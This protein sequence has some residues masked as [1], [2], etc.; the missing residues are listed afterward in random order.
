[1]TQPN[2]G[3]TRR[4]QECLR[5]VLP[6][7][8]AEAGAFDIEALDGVAG[9]HHAFPVV[10]V[11]QAESVAELVDRFF[12]Q[13]LPEQV[14]TG[15]QAVE[16]FAQAVRGDQRAGALELGFAE[17]EG[18][19]RHVQVERGDRQQAHVFAGERLHELQDGGRVELVAQAVARDSYIEPV[20]A[21]LA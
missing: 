17:D 2:A 6:A 16:L 3:R 14:G 20:G 19:H 21:P 8:G 5:H 7:T 4:R 10:A 12:E 11:A 13:A 1:M 18:Q 15:R 9:R